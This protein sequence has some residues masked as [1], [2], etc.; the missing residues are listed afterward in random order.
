MGVLPNGPTYPHPVVDPATG[1]LKDSAGKIDLLVWVHWR[2]LLAS[3]SVFLCPVGGAAAIL[4][5]GLASQQGLWGLREGLWGWEK[6]EAGRLA[7]KQ[8]PGAVQ[9]EPDKG[10]ERADSNTVGLSLGAQ[11]REMRHLVLPEGDGP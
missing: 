3:L 1:W 8:M 6:L 9:G 7:Q 2:R 5:E 11:G 4:K 10:Q